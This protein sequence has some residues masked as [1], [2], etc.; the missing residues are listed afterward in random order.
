METECKE[1]GL[2][3]G[4]MGNLNKTSQVKLLRSCWAK[5]V[6]FKDKI[7]LSVSLQTE[8]PSRIFS[9]VK[10]HRFSTVL[11]FLEMVNI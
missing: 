9:Q 11:I 4:L 2:V 3:D 1:K 10:I 8:N 6:Q 7:S 5:L